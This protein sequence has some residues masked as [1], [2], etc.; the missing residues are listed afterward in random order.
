[1]RRQVARARRQVAQARRQ[2]AQVRRQVA[3]VRRQV[4]QEWWEEW[5][6]RQTEQQ[7]QRAALLEREAGLPDQRQEQPAWQGE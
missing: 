5:P 1:V 7:V 4:A 3:Q 6:V 2:V